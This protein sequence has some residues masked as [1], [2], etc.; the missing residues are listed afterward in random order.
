LQGLTGHGFTASRVCVVQMG[1]WFMCTTGMY[2]SKI[3]TLVQADMSDNHVKPKP[4]CRSTM[5]K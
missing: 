4:H 2:M 1:L 3:T 5:S